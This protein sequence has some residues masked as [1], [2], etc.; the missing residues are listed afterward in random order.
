MG[1][2]A[3]CIGTRAT[4][5]PVAALPSAILPNGAFQAV[6]GVRFGEITDGL[7]NTLLVGEKHVPPSFFLKYPIDCGLYDGHNPVCNTRAGGPDFP[8]ARFRDDPSWK[9]GSYHPSH[10][11]FAFCDG[12]V[13]MIPN[14][15]DPYV[16]GLLAAR[17]D[18]QAIPQY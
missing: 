18:G 13:R 14:S 17:N 15:I 9:F 6:T 7:T 4:D 1:D 12:S 2:Y 16:L 10:C 8:L 3:A 11:P 5:A